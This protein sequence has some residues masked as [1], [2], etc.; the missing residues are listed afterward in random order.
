[1]KGLTLL[2]IKSCN[3]SMVIKIDITSQK[4]QINETEKRAKK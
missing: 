1:M 3:K 2:N 4:R